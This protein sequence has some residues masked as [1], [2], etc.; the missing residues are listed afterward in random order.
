MHDPT[1][2]VFE[3]ALGLSKPWYV[4]ELSF[5]A[6]ARR[7]DIHLDFPRG[8][9]WAC[10]QCGAAGCPVHDTEEKRWRHLNFFQ[11]E[12]YL[13]ARVP[14]VKCKDHGVLQV[15][16]PWARPQSGFT[17]LFEAL[18]MAMLR[19]MPVQAASRIVGEHDTR[20]WRVLQHYVAEAR[21]REDHSEVVVVGVDET[22]NRR[23][24]DYLSLFVDLERATV[25]FATA[26][27]DK[28]TVAK[29]R[30]DLEAH[31]GRA[32]QVRE[33]SADMS[34]AYRAGIQ[35]QFPQAGLTIDKYHLVQAVNQ[36][37]DE[38]RRREQKE[39]PELKGSRFLWL[40]KPSRL[41]EG[42]RGELERMRRRSRHTTRAYEFKLSFQEL[43]QLPIERAHGHLL[44]W[45]ESVLR[46]RV[47]PLQP[48]RDLVSTVI[49]RWDEILRGFKTRI[50]N[51][52]LE[53]IN[54]LVQAAKRRA[55]GYRTTDN[56]IAMIYM[57]AGKL[58][59]ALPI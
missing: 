40:K 26:G 43:W 53:G 1:S 22:S 19:E 12:A 5:N 41:T 30:E 25:V 21:S 27:R 18:L 38:V 39:L 14:R 16:V 55:R 51:G 59:F 50:S 6:E 34:A 8:S 36:V 13:H 56:Y 42:Q 7:L 9:R 4:R 10:P 37:V 3:L 46:T 15:Q 45:C 33:F 20:L 57:I 54:S 28:G 44:E 17:L 31:G 24:Q 2:H 52:V 29:F 32:E 47:R 35:E 49:D 23:G 11:H 48:L 58:N